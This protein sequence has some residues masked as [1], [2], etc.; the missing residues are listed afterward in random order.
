V[1]ILNFLASTVIQLPVS[2]LTQQ[3]I[4]NVTTKTLLRVSI[5]KQITLN[6]QITEVISHNWDKDNTRHK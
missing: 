6:V 3:R 5:S 4:K 2:L 1:Q